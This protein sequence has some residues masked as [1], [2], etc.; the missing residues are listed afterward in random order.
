MENKVLIVDDEPSI[1]KVLSLFLKKEKY[2][3]D[4]ASSIS[5]TYK[6]LKKNEYSIIFLDINLPDG[7]SLEYFPKIK[8]I[9]HN[10]SIIVMTAQDTMDNAINSM[11]LGAYDY[12][13]KPINLDGDLLLLV[14]RAKENYL[15]NIQIQDLKKDLNNEKINDNKVVGKSASIQRIFKD[16]G[17]I[18]TSDHTVLIRGESGTGK[19]LIG[20]AIHQNSLNS[21][22]PYVQVNITAIPADLLESELFGYEKGAFTGAD[23]KKTGRFEEANNGTILLDEIG[24]MSVDL[25]SKL[26]RVLE[27]KK[28]YKLGSQKPTSFNCR[29]VTS[30]NKNLEELIDEK[31]FRDDLFYRLNTISI[32]LPPLRER[33]EDIPHLISF[34]LEKYLDRNGSIKTIDNNAIEALTSYE[35]PGNIRELENTIKKLSI[36]S[37]NS[38]LSVDDIEEY[39]PKIFS[40]SREKESNL[41]YNLLIENILNKQKSSNNKYKNIIKKVKT[42]IIESTLI[43]CKGDRSKAI[44]ELGLVSD[45]FDVLVKDLKISKEL[46]KSD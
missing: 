1:L 34:F 27:E 21:N 35:W 18:S 29:I 9:S 22:G 44:K 24:D 3:V 7:N 28:F 41:N 20:K 46:I 33:K 6:K 15:K 14:S 30:T 37:S 4:N 45:E 25:Q 17:K 10:S 40:K 19:E 8:D 43:K 26:L 5:D 39:F 31:K 2:S 42:T 13:D 38:N 32:D 23:K 12:I 11:K 36:M 16:I